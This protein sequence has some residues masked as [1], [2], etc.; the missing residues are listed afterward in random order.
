MTLCGGAMHLV[1]STFTIMKKPINDEWIFTRIAVRKSVTSEMTSQWID[2]HM[3][4]QLVWSEDCLCSLNYLK[5]VFI[6]V[7]VMF[8]FMRRICV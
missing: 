7:A 1:N 4:G 2:L 6:R 3:A 5:L 8:N